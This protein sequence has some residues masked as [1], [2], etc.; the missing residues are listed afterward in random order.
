MTEVADREAEA[1]LDKRVAEANGSPRPG[2]VVIVVPTSGRYDSRTARIAGT[3]RSRGH[4]V[5]ILARGEPGLPEEE[6]NA[7]G[8]RTIRTVVTKT[9]P[10]ARAQDA[11]R[12]H[13]SG[14][15]RGKVV[16]EVAE[17]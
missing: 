14:H 10:L 5:T 3:L 8:I 1:D 11:W 7:E 6:T 13:M 4:A 2:R 15:T 17:A 9:Y 16:L 12:N